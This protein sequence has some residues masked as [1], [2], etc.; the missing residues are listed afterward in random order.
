VIAPVSLASR[1]SFW[2]GICWGFLALIVGC[3]PKEPEMID[4][5]DLEKIKLGEVVR[6]SEMLKRPAEAVCVLAAYRDRLDETEPFSRQ[7]NAQ[8]TAMNFTL[9]EG[10]WAL[11]FVNGAK[12]D[13]QTFKQRHHYMVTWH[14]GVP[15]NFKPVHCTSVARALVTKVDNFWPALII[16]EER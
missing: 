5:R 2:A 7:V 15:R 14:E 16:G 12:V 4:P 3:S 10:G 9:H 11:A 1:R 13:V 8:L 6:M